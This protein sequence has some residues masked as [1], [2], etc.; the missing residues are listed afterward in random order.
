MLI[1]H[2]FIQLKG[3]KKKQWAQGVLCPALGRLYGLNLG[4]LG[5]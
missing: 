4:A 5:G 1:A 3:T 2:I